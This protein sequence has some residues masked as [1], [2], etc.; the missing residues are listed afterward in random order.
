MDYPLRMLL[1]G[2]GL[3]GQASDPPSLTVVFSQAAWKDLVARQPT[4]QGKAPFPSP[5]WAQE[6]L[7]WVRA[8]GAGDSSQQVRIE[9]LVR[10]GDTA[11][12]RATLV[13]N[14]DDQGLDFLASPWTL[15]TA[16]RQAFSG[17]TRIALE[18]DGKA[19]TVETLR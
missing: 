17:A 14:A 19:G 15:A 10:E 6:V 18:F 16:G 7:L 8:G 9:G 1:S 2:Y 5:D 12:V 3:P 11:R 4:L 13:I